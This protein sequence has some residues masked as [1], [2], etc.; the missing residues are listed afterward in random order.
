LANINGGMPVSVRFAGKYAMRDTSGEVANAWL[1]ARHAMKSTT[2]AMIADCVSAV[3][4]LAKILISGKAVGARLAARYVLAFTSG[5]DPIALF[6]GRAGMTKQL[7]Y[8]SS[9]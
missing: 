9:G 6:V 5:M 8:V 7:T 4:R 1:A 2:G 3:V